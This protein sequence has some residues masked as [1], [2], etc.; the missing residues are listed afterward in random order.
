[1]N[2]V[3]SR[4]LNWRKTNSECYNLSGK[5]GEE[6]SVEATVCLGGNGLW[7]AWIAKTK[8]GRFKKRGVGRIAGKSMKFEMMRPQTKGVNEAQRWVTS[9]WPAFFC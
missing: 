8:R 4:P 6:L 5:D 3:C 2:K 1:M 9:N 7:S